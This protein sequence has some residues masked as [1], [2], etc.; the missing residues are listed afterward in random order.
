MEM[1]FDEVRG[2]PKDIIGRLTRVMKVKTTIDI[3]SVRNSVQL[4]KSHKSLPTRLPI[5]FRSGK[6]I[7]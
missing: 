7:D 3:G 1:R 4:L 2:E 6:Q 5:V